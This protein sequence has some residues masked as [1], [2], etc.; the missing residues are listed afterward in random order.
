MKM[1]VACCL[2]TF[3]AT[4]FV[5]RA[6]TARSAAAEDPRLAHMVFFAL[7]DSTPE[8]RERLVAA[9]HTLSA[10]DGVTY[11]SVGTRAEDVEE[12]GVTVKDFDVALQTVFESKEAKEAYL[13]HPIHKAF[14]DDNKDLWSHVRVFDSYITIPPAK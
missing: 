3:V 5:L 10:I 11:F 7:A 8:N 1:L 9:C 6:T 2:L 14:V 4:T 13:V 12:P